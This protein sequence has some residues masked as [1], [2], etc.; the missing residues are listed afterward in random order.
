[1]KANLRIILH[2]DQG[3]LVFALIFALAAALACHH[4][5]GTETGRSSNERAAGPSPTVETKTYQG[6]GIVKA[7]N[8]KQL[9]IEIAHEDIK[10]LMPAM[11]M[12][13]YVKEESLLDGL[14][15]GDSVSFVMVN[16][17]GGLKITEI[18]KR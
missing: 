7:V 9:A 10:D 4:P 11:Q 15:P 5:A 2:H 13:F 8:R 3:W 17:V 18:R 16:G 6:V 1:M 12:A 14:K